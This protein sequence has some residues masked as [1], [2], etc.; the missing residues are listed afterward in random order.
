MGITVAVPGARKIDGHQLESLT[1][2]IWATTMAFKVLMRLGHQDTVESAIVWAQAW[3]DRNTDD[4]AQRIWSAEAEKVIEWSETW[5]RERQRRR[6]RREV[7]PK[8]VSEALREKEEVRCKGSQGSKDAEILGDHDEV[9][10]AMEHMKISSAKTYSSGEDIRKG[11]FETFA[12]ADRM[13]SGR[14]SPE[15]WQM[16]E[17][18]DLL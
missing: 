15:D 8:V 6:E 18:E 13:A 16:I 1:P 10:D 14:S 5:K 11:I 3:L 4:Q 17:M 12:L 7:T 2:Q 9:T